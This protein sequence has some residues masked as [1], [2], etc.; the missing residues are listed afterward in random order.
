MFFPLNNTQI[1]LYRLKIW[2]MPNHTPNKN[3][4]ISS[5]SSTYIYFK[6]TFLVHCIQP[7]KNRFASSKY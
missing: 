1:P 6:Q 3:L 4:G 7:N 2:L 5:V